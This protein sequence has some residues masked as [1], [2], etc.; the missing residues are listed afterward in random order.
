MAEIMVQFVCPFYVSYSRRLYA[1]QCRP[2]AAF[3]AVSTVEIFCPREICS[4][5]G[6]GGCSRWRCVR[7]GDTEV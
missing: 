1:L 2:A 6:F 3:G 4:L 7:G 5:D